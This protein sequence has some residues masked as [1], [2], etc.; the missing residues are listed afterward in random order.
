MGEWI[1]HVEKEFSEGK[2]IAV[3][4]TSPS[5]FGISLATSNKPVLTMEDIKGMKIGIYGQWQTKIVKAIGAVDVAVPP[6]AVYENMQRKIVDSSFL[7][8]EFLETQKVKEIGKYL[9][10]LNYLFVPFWQVMNQKTWDSLPADVQKIMMDEAVKIPGYADTYA[11]N[12]EWH[13]I[14]SVKN[15][16]GWELITYPENELAK[17]RAAQAPIK[18]EFI[19]ML[20]KKGLDGKKIMETW[21]ELF[22]KYKK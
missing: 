16:Y 5:P 11:Y 4:A 21:K 13:A 6:P 3:F 10:A 12:I 15:D 9:H 8:P 14:N 2:L 7:D 20:N 17:F 1:K 19:E 22:A 18:A